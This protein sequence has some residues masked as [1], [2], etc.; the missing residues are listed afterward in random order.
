M[1]LRDEIIP[2]SELHGRLAAIPGWHTTDGISI[3]R[4]YEIG[5]DD[6]IRAVTEIGHA[7]VEL[8]HRPDIDIRWAGLTVYLTTHTAG[9]VVTELD[10]LTAARVDEIAGRHGA[11]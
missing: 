10:F 3:V 2:A 11:A 1:A 8:E 4:T 7:A 6:A 5:Y 9:D